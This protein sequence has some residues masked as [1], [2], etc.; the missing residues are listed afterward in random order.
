MNNPL[1]QPTPA[2]EVRQ[3]VSSVQAVENISIRQL[4]QMKELK[5]QQK[6]LKEQKKS[7]MENDR[8]LTDAEN[9]AADYLQAIKE[10]KAKIKQQRDFVEIDAKEKELKAEM[11]ELGVSLNNNL[12]NYS[13]LTGSNV[14]E[15]DEGKEYKIKHQVQ[16]KSG[17]LRL[18]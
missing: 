16:V 8:D 5:E 1:S 14:I 4:H 2:A 15:D 17:Q 13:R 9:N 6:L 12:T 3:D 11:K 18:L 7:I 10:A